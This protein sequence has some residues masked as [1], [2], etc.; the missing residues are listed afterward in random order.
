[1]ATKKEQTIDIVPVK[2]S[3]LTYCVLGRTPLILNRMSE[4]AKHELL[5]PKG[6]KSTAEKARSLKH[7]PRQE[8]IDSPYLDPSEQAATY[9]QHLATAFKK[10]ICATGVDVPGA[11][12]A[13][14]GRLMWVEGE[15][16]AIHGN[17]RM[18]MSVTRSADMNR[19][20]DIRT[21]AIVPEWACQI[22]I[23]YINPLL[24]ATVLSNL[25]A[26]AGLIQGIGDWRPQKGSGNYGQFDI[27]DAKD[28]NWKRVMKIGRQSQIQD[29]QE[30]VP[31]DRETE[32]LLAWFDEEVNVRGVE[33]DSGNVY[34]NG[35]DAPS[36][37]DRLS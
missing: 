6:R 28:P 22:S 36:V 19:T 15:R 25:L 18:F 4:K 26:T 31:Y 14:L 9:V 24:N 10:A 8:F 21:R 5:M 13:Q 2:E 7:H 3:R 20:P 32:E 11:T 37:E 1:M 12:K 34:G 35:H 30:A 33:V 27:V 29:M 23:S 17:V 16:I